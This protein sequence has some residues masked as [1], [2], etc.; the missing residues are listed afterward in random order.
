MNTVFGRDNLQAPPSEG[1]KDEPLN[2]GYLAA[3]QETL[4]EWASPEDAA[5]YDSL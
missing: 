2:K 4:S 1:E 5:A 3:V